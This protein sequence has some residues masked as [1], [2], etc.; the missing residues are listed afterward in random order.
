MSLEVSFRFPTYEEK[1]EFEAL[2][3][4]RGQTLSQLTR[5]C[6]YKYR[7]D[8][9]NGAE[10][11]KAYRARKRGEIASSTTRTAEAQ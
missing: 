3:A 6:L 4:N 2:A 9:S 1:Q 5:W 8:R 10:A 11:S 7:M